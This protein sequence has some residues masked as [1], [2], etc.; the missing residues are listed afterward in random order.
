M[1]IHRIRS[2]APDAAQRLFDDALQSRGPCLGGLR[3]LLGPG[4]AQQRERALQRVRDRRGMVTSPR[5]DNAEKFVRPYKPA[6]L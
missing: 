1:P 4:S 5:D 3:G 6:A 2:R